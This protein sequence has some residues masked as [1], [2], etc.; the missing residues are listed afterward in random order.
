MSAV[1]ALGSASVSYREAPLTLL[2]R[3]A[4]Q[5]AE[6]PTALTRLV[7]ASGAR[8]AAILATCNRTE[9]YATFTGPPDPA[10]LARFLVQD[11][12][13]APRELHSTLALRTG[14]DTARH[15]LR[16]AA[17]LDSMLVFEHEIQGQVRAAA[18]LAR[19]AGVL[20]GDLSGLFGWAQLAGHRVRREV[21]VDA[22]HRSLGH[23]AIDAGA[24]I[25]GGLGGRTVLV[26]GTGK[27]AAAVA[28]RARQSGAA[29][30][31]CGRSQ[32]RAERLAGDPARALALDGLA[33]SLAQTDLVVAC[34]AVRRPL[35]G[36]SE[37][38]RAVTE[39]TGKPLAAIDLAVPRSIDPAVRDLPGIR[40]L[41]L[42]GLGHVGV[43]DAARLSEALGIG[44][45]IA[46]EETRRY[47]AWDS[48]RAAGPTIAA[49]QRQAEQLCERELDRA[50]GA[51]P[52]VDR[53]AAGAALH[54]VVAKL[55][56][57]PL[58]MAREAA[59]AGDYRL[60]ADLGRMFDLDA[61]RRE[62][63]DPPGR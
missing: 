61:G 36:A 47:L 27:I 59:A 34:V 1:A 49:I 46:E 29:L 42:E 41:D 16:V 38:R 55:L 22:P 31:V 54:R 57:G 45:R 12:A 62:G 13:L 39:R 60:L 4:Y 48:G 14:A 21:P 11:H 7:A 43:Q 19:Q 23:A 30:L 18:E 6:I 3:L 28:E 37:L 32:E 51:R 24:D 40:L 53:A 52:A 56:H 9:V 10:A 50:V 20:G 25:L 63:A 44:E 33:A 35:L 26:V 5:P 15:L 2:D 58:V 17:G 8:E